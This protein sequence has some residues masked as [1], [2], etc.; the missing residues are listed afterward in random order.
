[1]ADGHCALE[2]QVARMFCLKCRGIL[3]LVYTNRMEVE[4]RESRGVGKSRGIRHPRVNDGHEMSG[5]EQ[6]KNLV[7]ERSSRSCVLY[8]TKCLLGYSTRRSKDKY[9]SSNLVVT[10]ILWKRDFRTHVS[11]RKPS[12]PAAQDIIPARKK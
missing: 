5:G 10:F 8:G 1:M 6:G 3:G 2:I 9:S 4:V 7:A 12:A 11:S